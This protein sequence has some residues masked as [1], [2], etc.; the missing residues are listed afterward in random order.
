MKK[1]WVLL[2]VMSLTIGNGCFTYA[3]QNEKGG[4]KILEEYDNKKSSNVNE[5]KEINKNN[6][7]NRTNEVKE[8]K[9]N[10]LES[11]NEK[12]KKREDSGTI[13]NE[14][15]EEGARIEINDNEK[16]NIERVKSGVCG[17]NI[18]WSLNDEGELTINGT[19]NMMEYSRNEIPWKSYF[20]DII[21]I[22]IGENITFLGEYTFSGCK[23]LKNINYN[24]VNMKDYSRN[25]H[26]YFDSGENTGRVTI[27]IGKNVTRIP[28]AF[29]CSYNTDN[30]IKEV[31][32]DEKSKCTSIGEYAFSYCEK[33]KK[34]IIP[35]SMTSIEKRAFESCF[36]LLLQF[37]KKELPENLQTHWS[38]DAAVCLNAV[39]FGETEYGQQYWITSDN[40]AYV[41]KYNGNNIKIVIPDKIEDA[42]VVGIA[43][44]A[45]SASG[46]N[47][48]NM[49]ISSITIPETIEYIGPSAFDGCICLNELNYNA[50]SVE[51]L[52]NSNCTFYNVGRHTTE[53][54]TITFGKSVK[55]IPANL[56]YP[57][58][59]SHGNDN[60][61]TP[62]INKVIFENG[63]QCKSIGKSSFY[64]CDTLKSIE[65]PEGIESIDEIAF[66]WCTKLEKIVVPDSLIKISAS[67]FM[68]CSKI[69][70]AGPIGGGYDF[71]FG[72]KDSLPQ[73]AFSEFQKYSTFGSYIEEIKLPNTIKKIGAYAFYGT[74]I[75]NIDLPNEVTEID[76]YAFAKCGNLQSL[77]IPATV[78]KMEESV[79]SGCTL[80]TSAG[81]IG[82]KNALQFG[83][84]KKIPDEA[85]HNAD[86][87]TEKIELP[88]TIESI[89]AYSFANSNVSEIILSDKVTEIDEKA[90]YGCSK[91]QSLVIPKTVSKMG[92]GVFEGC[93]L[94]K[95]AGPIGTK[96][97]L[98][99]GW[100][101]AIP[102]GAFSMME[103]LNQVTLPK[104][105][106]KI[107]GYAF[108]STGIK[109]LELPDEIS[110]IDEGAFSYCRYLENVNIPNGISEINEYTFKACERLKKV[111]IPSNVQIIKEA[112]FDRYVNE[113]M[114]PCKLTYVEKN[115]FGGVRTIYYEG[116]EKN[117]NNMN[118]PSSMCASWVIWNYNTYSSK[119][120]KGIDKNYTYTVRYFSKWDEDSQ[121]AYFGNNDL[122]GSQVTEESNKAFLSNLD[123]LVG[124][125]VW[126]EAKNRMDGKIDSEYLMDIKSVES[127]YG[128]VTYVNGRNITIENKTYQVSDEY[129]LPPG[130]Q[131]D[132]KVL[133]H[134]YEEKIVGI[135]ELKCVEGVLSY[136]NPTSRKLKLPKECILSEFAEEKAVDF[137]G[138]ETVY[139]ERGVKYWR[140]TLNYVY[141][142]QDYTFP[143]DAK[144][145]DVPLYKSDEERLLSVYGNDWMEA[146]D[147]YIN[148]LNK[149]LEQCVNEEDSNRESL[150]AKEADRMQ[151]EDN[152]SKENKYLSFDKEFPELYKKRA[153]KAVATLLYDEANKQFDFSSVDF[154]SA[155]AGTALIKSVMNS[156]RGTSHEYDYG[157]VVLNLNVTM[158]GESQFGSLTCK[159]K[160]T[161]KIS[162]AIICSTQE[163]C[164]KTVN[165]YLD[166]LKNTASSAAYN[167]YSSI[168]T[169]VLGKPLSSLTSE[170][171]EKQ[172]RIIENKTINKVS[173]KMH[174]AG[175]GNLIEDLNECYNYYNMAIR[176]LKN[177]SF[178]KLEDVLP[179]LNN[180]KFEDTTI[181]K[182][183]VSK[184]MNRLNKACTKLNKATADYLTG[185]LKVSDIQKKMMATFNCPVN[186]AVFNS[187]N[188]QIGYIG[189][190][191]IWYTDK[192]IITENGD[193]KIISSLTE[194]K[195]TYKITATDYGTMSC[196]FEEYD[197]DNKPTGRLNYYNV[198]LDLEQE[199]LINIP[200][201][202]KKEAENIKLISKDV[203]ISA[204]EFIQAN[205]KGGVWI[206]CKPITEGDAVGGEITGAG[207][208]VKG[209]SVILTA[210]PN[211]GYRFVGWFENGKLVE[212]NSEYKFTADK[213]RDVIARFE[214]NDYLRV[215]VEKKGL[216]GVIGGGKYLLGEKAIVQA[217]PNDGERFDGWY[218]GGKLV[219]LER[220]YE[221]EVKENITLI[222][223]FSNLEILKGDVNNDGIVDIQDLKKLLRYVC[224]KENL[225]EDQLL[226]GNVNNDE[227][228]D[229]Q[230]LRKLLQ[231]ICGKETKL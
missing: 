30:Y 208:Y 134:L 70:T 79:F 160:K 207:E 199:Y 131:K 32:F 155:S 124:H 37:E 24:A 185:N 215:N 66:G 76:R 125:Y 61:Y 152:S 209:N 219:S 80:L 146:Y 169:D 154:S 105:V 150:I 192:L 183:A 218:E 21:T 101:K 133:F 68:M 220:E 186:V 206:I 213:D 122:L 109:N 142:I 225:T 117:R 51:D 118:V 212:T 96:N 205:E 106:E 82:T 67:A 100:E 115:N 163:D 200:T 221:F 75:S 97:S 45:F 36:N 174:I 16:K 148:V 41:W 194:D 203:Q 64:E 175:V 57:Y 224:G 74:G 19:G 8:N 190:D 11:L 39:K 26:L 38:G 90:F 49:K 173:E 119:G 191:D 182:A 227:S 116:D 42:K 145:Y 9:N 29:F 121:T 193:S 15:G 180:L 25:T 149:I 48:N 177:G 141:S 143:E 217:I 113:L 222:A 159:I 44:S 88:N 129:E 63:N 216:G 162:T 120:F 231:Y 107:G 135:E 123:N 31:I 137:L 13:V 144:Y 112:A 17:E 6:V 151:K 55:R 211:D 176:P 89:G 170:Y 184:A 72:W 138:K 5:E 54:V 35:A 214:Q 83:W 65:L 7:L 202:I 168:C 87:I 171:L 33:L 230:D 210:V 1:I 77:I 104:S 56:F 78:S 166:E 198:P 223:K 53:G 98:Q 12:E 188:E 59:S 108:E 172:I 197:N 228:V 23:N 167:V 46:G 102:F 34:M 164:Q 91:L 132:E 196:S 20:D 157:E 43:A 156:L 126:V 73:Y 229:I 103:S 27:F 84:T 140:D 127:R 110:I 58:Y 181:E 201:D 158:A 69:K 60:E 153:Y 28:S 179:K 161:N 130:V 195:L 93:K 165:A 111:F 95:S 128:V 71:E 204:D 47:D 22:T 14:N 99:F 52:E 139:T 226:V 86:S 178:N 18:V 3:A 114:I 92:M 4:V 136:W 2:V 85:F 189:D 187:E 50:Q 62:K 94:L 10:G 40:T 147:K 81:G